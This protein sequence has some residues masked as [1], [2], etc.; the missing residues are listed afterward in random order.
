VR[1]SGDLTQRV[2]IEIFM[3]II[4]D[5][6]VKAEHLRNRDDKHIFRDFNK[7]LFESEK[8]SYIMGKYLTP[9]FNDVNTILLKFNNLIEFKEKKPIEI[10]YSNYEANYPLL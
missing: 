2:F 3:D 4:I 9:K 5:L 10:G 6:Y 1:L 7:L 8:G